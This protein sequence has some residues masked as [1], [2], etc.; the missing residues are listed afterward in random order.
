MNS[1]S[2]TS[3]IPLSVKQVV[4]FAMAF[5]RGGLRSNTRD[6]IKRNSNNMRLCE[7]ILLHECGVENNN[8]SPFHTNKSYPHSLFNSLVI[9]F[10][11]F[12]FYDIL[13]LSVH[14]TS[15]TTLQPTD[16]SSQNSVRVRCYIVNKKYIRK[17]K[18]SLVD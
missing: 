6:S 10:N 18:A 13:F 11:V 7:K 2:S 12:F 8:F 14:L 17:G 1:N 5:T 16:A 3:Y 15:L 4:K 9:S